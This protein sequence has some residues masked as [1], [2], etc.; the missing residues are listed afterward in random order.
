MTDLNIL[1]SP[2]E[3]KDQIERASRV[4]QCEASVAARLA[5]DITFCEINYGEGIFSWLQLASSGAEAI[6][7][8]LKNAFLLEIPTDQKQIDACWDSPIPFALLAR[9]L[10]LQEIYGVSWSC[11]TDAISG[12]TSISSV[13]LKFDNSFT[14]S[15][16]QK[17]LDALSNGVEV[18]S[19][20]WNELNR[21]AAEFLLSEETLDAC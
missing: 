18:S 5:D 17:M 14:P 6:N 15:S 13:H 7:K 12:N 21:I 2:R 4:I 11:Q 1:V 9:S 19:N 3:I 8:I 16:N 10:H 20:E